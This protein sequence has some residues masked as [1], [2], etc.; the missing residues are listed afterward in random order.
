[1]ACNM[2]SISHFIILIDESDVPYATIGAGENFIEAVKNY[3]SGLDAYCSPILD[4]DYNEECSVRVFRIPDD[5]DDA[6]IDSFCD[7]ESD[8]LGSEIIKLSKT[9]AR[10]DS[11][12]VKVKFRGEEMYFE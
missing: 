3:Y 5:F 10:F 2:E 11:S 7:M 8:A 9:D 1:M 4:E 12:T 6:A